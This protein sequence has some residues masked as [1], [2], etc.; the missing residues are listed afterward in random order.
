MNKLTF[1]WAAVL[2]YQK[3]AIF[4]MI[5]VPNCISWSG[6]QA[7]RKQFYK[8]RDGFPIL[9]VAHSRFCLII[10]WA[11]KLTISIERSVQMGESDSY[12]K[13]TWS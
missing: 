13:Q 7:K 1:F 6:L 5:S 12:I 3:S 9:L 8:T 11:G 10:Q 2:L 4:K